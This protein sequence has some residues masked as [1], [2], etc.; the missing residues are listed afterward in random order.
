MLNSQ[1]SQLE[2]P[3]QLRRLDFTENVNESLHPLYSHLSNIA[4]EEGR[5]K[6]ESGLIEFLDRDAQTKKIVDIF[7][8]QS[9]NNQKYS[10]AKIS[11]YKSLNQTGQDLSSELSLFDNRLVLTVRRVFE[12]LL[13]Y[14]LRNNIM[15]DENYYSPGLIRQKLKYKRC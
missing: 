14:Q 7:K 2:S 8:Q 15:F 9:Q 11:E 5:R 3:D 10:K 12:K 13:D 1:S 4:N 6:Y